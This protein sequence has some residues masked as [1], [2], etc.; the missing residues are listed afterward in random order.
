MSVDLQSI[1][2]PRCLS[3]KGR[4]TFAAVVELCQAVAEHANKTGPDRRLLRIRELCRVMGFTERNEFGAV[5]DTVFKALQPQ[6]T[7]AF[8]S[9]KPM[10]ED[11]KKLADVALTFGK[12]RGETL[13]S[14]PVDYLD[15]CIGQEWF[16]R[17][18]LF[19]AVSRY[20]ELPHVKR[21]ID[22]ALSEREYG[23][24]D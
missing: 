19:H 17:H 23:M 14:V 7:P 5:A 10:S 20:L 12:H 13:D 1:R 22:D 24:D 21:E 6:P 16:E 2:W 9:D 3:D 4:A 11:D 18:P 8:E 15:W